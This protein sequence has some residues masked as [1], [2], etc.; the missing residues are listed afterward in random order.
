MKSV[1]LRLCLEGGVNAFQSQDISTQTDS[2]LSPSV[3]VRCAVG[4]NAPPSSNSRVCLV[5]LHDDR[6]ATAENYLQVMKESLRGTS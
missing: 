6:D 4:G 2:A 5:N 3:T 1:S